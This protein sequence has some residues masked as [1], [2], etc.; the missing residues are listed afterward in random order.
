MSYDVVIN[1]NSTD[2]NFMLAQRRDADGMP[3]KG[4]KKYRVKD[5]PLMPETLVT[6]VSSPSTLSPDREVQIIQNDW[7]K[8]IQD[9]YFADP[10]KYQDSVNC[11]AR[12]KGKVMLSPQKGSAISFPSYAT[13]SITDGGLEGWNGDI[14]DAPWFEAGNGVI[15]NQTE[16][17]EGSN[18]AQQVGSGAADTGSIYQSLSW[19]N[20]YRGDVFTCMAWIKVDDAH[21]DTWGRLTLYDGQN[22]VQ[23]DKVYATS[24][25]PV[26]VSLLLH[27]A[28]DQIKI[29]L[30]YS[31]ADGDNVYFDDVTKLAQ[32]TGSCSKIMQFGDSIVVASD[33]SLYKISSG[34]LQW[35]TTFPAAITDL[36]VYDGRLFIAQGWSA[37]YWYTSDLEA[38]NYCTLANST[39]KHMSAVGGDQFWI[40]NTADTVT[41]S[42]DPIVGGT[43]FATPVYTVGS[44]DYDITGLVDNPEGT[45]YVRKQSTVYYLDSSGVDYE[46]IPALST[47][48]NTSIN[49]DMYIWKGN[50]YIPSG[51]N[52]LY[53]YDNGT[54]TTI[55]PVRYASG[56]SDYDEEILA[57]CGDTAYLYAI[58]TV[59][60]SGQP[61]WT[62]I[63]SGRWETVAGSTDW[64]WHPLYRFDING[65]TAI[66]I[67]SADVDKQLYMGTGTAGD[68]ITPF[69]TS[70]SYSNPTGETN[71]RA[72][73]A[74][75]FDTPFFTSTFPKD[76]KYWKSVNLSYLAVTG[77]GIEIHK[78]TD[79]S[80]FTSIGNVN[81]NS[82][83]NTMTFNINS[84]STKMMLRFELT[85]S[86]VR[87]T[88]II[89]GLG[90]M[91]FGIKARVFGAQQRQIEATLRIAAGVRQ[92]GT[93][94]KTSKTISTELTNLR[95][96]YQV[97]DKMTITGPDGT[98]YN[99]IFAR[100]GYEEQMVFDETGKLEEW[101]VTVRFLEI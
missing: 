44:T 30:D 16:E 22:T 58:V 56:D 97:D 2:Y 87:Y 18:C 3:R 67:S 28:A 63:L 42:D 1:Y 43:A 37:N 23:S 70:P 99:V 91:G 76:M 27:A 4:D 48:A 33:K 40:S 84:A 13:S 89:Y 90:G 80:S 82:A 92:R 53:E 55:S 73:A 65:A 98:P 77:T 45:V 10:R 75:N 68:G 95:T 71:F 47:E 66:F 17:Y 24:W 12:Y 100:G 86:N 85:A 101:E 50:L 79:G 25:T 60:V 61:P 72:Q 62:K 7:R 19:S 59:A 21:T 36:C 9:V 29:T 52:S 31:V 74:G 51:V 49:Y 41:D 14:I 94:T 20:N 15:N 39:A 8:G 35:L 57:I 88:P 26:I 6:G 34:A 54:V 46:L 38:F 81:T 78:S 83:I 5:A 32:D 96:L 64:Y 93:N 11:D 69:W